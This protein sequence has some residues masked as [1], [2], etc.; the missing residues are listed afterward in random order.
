[1]QK[2]VNSNVRKG[3]PAFKGQYL[4]LKFDPAD[5]YCNLWLEED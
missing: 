2:V 3:G 4:D 5:L 1:M